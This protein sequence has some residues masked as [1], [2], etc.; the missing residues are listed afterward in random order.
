[1][2]PSLIAPK[3]DTVIVPSPQANVRSKPQISSD[4]LVGNGINVSDR[5]SVKKSVIGHH[6]TIK[7]KSKIVGSVLMDHVIVEER[8]TIQNCVLSHHVHIEEGTIL[9][10]CSVG[11]NV[12]I[13][14]G[15]K[16]IFCVL[17]WKFSYCFYFQWKSK[18]KHLYQ[19]DYTFNKSTCNIV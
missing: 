16:C 5:S 19:V 6:C 13:S 17:Y 15:S 9:K 11:P 3:S 12:V 10:D 4:S 14:K 1:M 18:E 2:Y 8:A 7:D